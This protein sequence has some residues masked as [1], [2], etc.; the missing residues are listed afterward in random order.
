MAGLL[1]RPLTDEE[2]ALLRAWQ[3]SGRTSLYLR[4]RIVL[5]AGDEAR[6]S[7]S[8]GAGPAVAGVGRCPS[9]LASSL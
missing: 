7:P 3:D 8:A 2:R 1:R 4:A 9:P 6:R 5:L